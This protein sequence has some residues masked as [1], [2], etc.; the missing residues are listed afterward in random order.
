M[1]EGFFLKRSTYPQIKEVAL[2]LP[3][4]VNTETAFAVR[5]FSSTCQ[6]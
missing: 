5:Q 6:S 3:V 1:N 4:L 2:Y